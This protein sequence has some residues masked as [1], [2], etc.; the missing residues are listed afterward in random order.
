MCVAMDAYVCTYARTLRRGR[1]CVYLR[2]HRMRIVCMAV[3]AVAGTSSMRIAYMFR[4]YVG[5]CTGVVLN[6]QKV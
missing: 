1:T 5:T 3:E 2:V 6:Y 4:T